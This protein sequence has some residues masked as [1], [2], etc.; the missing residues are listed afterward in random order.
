[1]TGTGG[2]AVSVYA[3]LNNAID[4]HAKQT[5]LGRFEGVSIDIASHDKRY[6]SSS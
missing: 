3:L 6:R 1:M 2:C 5:T 4:S